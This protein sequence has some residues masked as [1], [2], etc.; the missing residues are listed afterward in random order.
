MISTGAEGHYKDLVYFNS[1]RNY[2]LALLNA[3]NEVHN[4]VQDG[5]KEKS[6]TV[7][8]SFGNY[9][10]SLSI[11]DKTENDITSLNFNFL[12]R[13][14][15]SFEG[16]A[17]VAERQTQ[18]YQKISKAVA[19]PAQPGKPNQLNFAYNSLAYDFSFKLLLQARGL[20]SATQ[21][22]ET[23]LAKFNPTLNLGIDE[24]PLLETT[25]T[26][27]QISDPE[28]E[29]IEEFETTDVNV[30]NVTFD[31]TVRGNIYSPIG[32][33]GSI[34]SI[35]IYLNIWEA[36]RISDSKLAAY[37]RIDKD[38][39]TQRSFNGT[40][41]G[42]MPGRLEPIVTGPEKDLIDKRPDYHPY[43]SKEKRTKP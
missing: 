34:E 4:Y 6:F 27:I 16:L 13:L 15:L 7:P 39:V 37:W 30:I 14:V 35:G 10:K 11:E 19:I 42:S 5:D 21:I 20:T 43:E 31:V 22:T 38:E 41:R 29:I 24:F 23:I 28:F 25:E 8:I 3:F 12:P 26:Q 36:R 33:M 9:E 2:T 1:T 17:K 32:L 40:G 18:K